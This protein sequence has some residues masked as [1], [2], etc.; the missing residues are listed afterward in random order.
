MTETLVAF[1]VVGILVVMLARVSIRIVNEYD[2]LGVF[3]FG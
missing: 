1:A 2:R 3:R